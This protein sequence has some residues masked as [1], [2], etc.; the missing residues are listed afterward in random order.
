MLHN[1]FTYILHSLNGQHLLDILFT[2]RR[3][4]IIIFFFFVRVFNTHI[5]KIFQI[6][7][8]G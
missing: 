4:V 1:K 8:K 2:H 7:S 3:A 6:T 5:I